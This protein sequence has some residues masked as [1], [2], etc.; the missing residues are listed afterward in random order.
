MPKCSSWRPVQDRTTGENIT[1][2]GCLPER[3]DL[4]W[5]PCR[6]KVDEADDRCDECWDLLVQHPSPTVRS[7]LLD[8][9]A[10][11]GWVMDLLVDDPD[12]YVALLA[13]RSGM[14]PTS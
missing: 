10:L 6:S 1:H 9:N 11:P 3:C 14:A 7:A 2:E 8:E 13:Q 5:K 4:H 12:D